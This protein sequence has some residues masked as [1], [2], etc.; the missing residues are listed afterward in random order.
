MKP[1]RATNK[2]ILTVPSFALLG[3]IS[4][5]L[6]NSSQGQT[7]VT[8]ETSR[9]GLNF[10]SLMAATLPS[11]VSFYRAE[12]R[13]RRAEDDK[14][15]A[16]K[17]RV[18]QDAIDD[19]EKA[20][21]AAVGILFPDEDVYQIRANIMTISTD[22]S[23]K[24]WCKSNNMHLYP[25][26][27]IAFKCGEGCVGEVWRRAKEYPMSTRWQPAYA[28]PITLG[29]EIEKHWKISREQIEKTKHLIWILST[30]IFASYED[31]SKFIGVL[32]F[33]GVAF[34][35]NMKK[36]EDADIHRHCVDIAEHIGSKMVTVG[37]GQAS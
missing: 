8:N 27:N 19:I 14:I 5:L 20:L 13:A 28:S 24:I 35:K 29:S 16:E 37:V 6:L 21:I 30:P 4:N 36:L 3:I 7:L 17:D 1:V 9:L 11:L 22:N 25:D 26:E 12:M 31:Y 33:D 32:N 23:L 2:V 18:R 15:R 10:V 34:L